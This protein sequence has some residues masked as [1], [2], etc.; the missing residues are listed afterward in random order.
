MGTTIKNIHFLGQFQAKAGQL[1]FGHVE[2]HDILPQIP[3]FNY[4]DVFN[5]S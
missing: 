4:N 2:S 5:E 3:V 1:C